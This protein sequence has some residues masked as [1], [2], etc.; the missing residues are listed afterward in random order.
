MKDIKAIRGK[1][2]IHSLIQEGE[3]EHQDFKFAVNDAAKR[4]HSISAFANNDGG[5]LLIGVKDNGNIAGIRSDEDIYVV[6]QAAQMYCQ[7]PQRIE[8]TAFAVDGGAV[9]I[10]VEIPKSDVRPVMSKEADGR[11]SA[12]YR[13]KDENIVAHPVMVK[14]WRHKSGRKSAVFSLTEAEASLL[15]YLEEWGLT[16]LEDY[17]RG[18]HISRPMAEDIVVNLYSAGI[19]DFVYSGSEFKIVRSQTDSDAL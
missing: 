10:R 15:S 3:H 18:A 7:P 17:M 19:I 2:Y 11:W 14:A 12:Y 16:T 5:R 9:V 1:F 13:V 4:A 8:V 6:E